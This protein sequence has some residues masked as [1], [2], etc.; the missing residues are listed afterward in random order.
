M[1]DLLKIFKLIVRC[2]YI[3]IIFF[4]NLPMRSTYAKFEKYTVTKYLT[5]VINYRIVLGGL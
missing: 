3:C 5:Q 2:T 4:S 1:N